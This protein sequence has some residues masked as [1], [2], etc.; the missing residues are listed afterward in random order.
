VCVCVYNKCENVVCCL[1][2]FTGVTVLKWTSNDGY[3]I[4]DKRNDHEGSSTMKQLNENR[5]FIREER[6][7]TNHQLPNFSLPHMLV[8]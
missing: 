1:T 3:I 7:V 8:I 2:K 6:D 5:K 4:D